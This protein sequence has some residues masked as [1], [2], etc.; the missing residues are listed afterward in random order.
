[1][2]GLGISGFRALQTCFG[3]G[4]TRLGPWSLIP[5]LGEALRP[6]GGLGCELRI[7]GLLGFEALKGAPGRCFKVPG[8]SCRRDAARDV[9][10]DKCGPYIPVPKTAEHI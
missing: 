10:V 2:R 7:S 4:F 3:E 1:M 5:G 9:E 8:R 6:Q